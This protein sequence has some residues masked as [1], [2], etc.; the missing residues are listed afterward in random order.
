[1]EITFVN[2]FHQIG[3]EITLNY[4][5]ENVLLFMFLAISSIIIK[6]FNY[7]TLILAIEIVII[8]LIVIILSIYNINADVS[9]E[10]FILY[11]LGIIAVET[12]ILLGI[13]IKY[14][15]VTKESSLDK[16]KNIKS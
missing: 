6:R 4:I 3:T 11:L 16:I 14:Y 8:S 9:F 5:I 13:I 7:I 15:Q 2:N 10:V 1:M 12:G